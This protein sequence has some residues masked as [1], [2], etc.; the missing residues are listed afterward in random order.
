MRLVSPVS[1][2]PPS[3]F[4]T[5]WEQ[6]EGD[7]TEQEIDDVISAPVTNTPSIRVSHAS[8]MMPTKMGEGQE[9]SPRVFGL[10]SPSAAAAAAVAAVAAAAAEQRSLSRG[11]SQGMDRG[12]GLRGSQEVDPRQ[13]DGVSYVRAD[14]KPPVGGVPGGV[15]HGLEGGAHLHLGEKRAIKVCCFASL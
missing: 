12:V 8:N 11:V 10:N 2:S 1:P 9:T 15:L 7:L 14:R 13:L 4:S 3:L 5:P 6:E